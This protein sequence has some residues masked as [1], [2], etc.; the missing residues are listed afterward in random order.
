MRKFLCT[1]VE[2]FVSSNQNTQRARAAPVKVAILI[3][4]AGALAVA[5]LG[6][7]YHVHERYRVSGHAHWT[8]A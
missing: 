5:V 1:C 2:D 8:L 3:S 6:T 7:M 4:N